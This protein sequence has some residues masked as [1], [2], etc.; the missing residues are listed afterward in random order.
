MQAKYQFLLI[1]VVTLSGFT[2]SVTAVS[3][4]SASGS[5][6]PQN[7]FPV[8]SKI[9]I[10]SV[11]AIATTRPQG[12]FQDGSGHSHNWT[13]NQQNS[14]TYDASMT[15]DLRVTG[16]SSNG[17]VQFTVLGGVMIVDGSTIGISE[18]SG[19]VSNVDRI[20]MQ[21]T[22]TSADSQSIN[23]H[24]NGLAALLNGAVVAEVSGNTLISVNGAPENVILTCLA[25]L[26]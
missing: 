8:G 10:R 26:S 17:G 18:G 15:V 7:Q 20:F 16:E 23:W 12:S 5:F 9:A 19:Q 2:V 13:Q 11:Y 22:A 3:A 21:G 25:T 1:M 14:P 6:N 24:M 4:Q